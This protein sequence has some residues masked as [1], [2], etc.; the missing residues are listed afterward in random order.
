VKAEAAPS[1]YREYQERV[2]EGLRGADLVV[3]PT[4]AMLD[5]LDEHYRFATPKRVISNGRSAAEFVPSQ[6]SEV[7]FSAGRVWDEAKN[8]ALLERIAPQLGWTVRIAGDAQPPHGT[9]AAFSHIKALG[10]LTREGLAQE[11]GSAAIYAAPAR[12]EP[13]GLGVLEAALSGCAL[14]LGDIP[15]LREIWEEAAVFVDSED[16]RGWI[17][18][19]NELS[20]DRARRA[21]LVSRSRERA[22][23]FTP[24]AMVRGYREAYQTI[25][26]SAAAPA[27]E[28]VAA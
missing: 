17:S 23:K 24:A 22:Q 4:A 10:F 25:R 18:A 28:A 13:F 1:R 6:K 8:L 5:V 9:T 26:R 14:V 20:A 15:S 21:A 7:I 2:A 3:A 12:Y 27:T 11:L 19:L 16:E